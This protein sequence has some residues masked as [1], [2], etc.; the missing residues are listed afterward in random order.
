MGNTPEQAYE[1]FENQEIE[2]FWDAGQ[3]DCDYECTILDCLRGLDK[4]I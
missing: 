4:A 1:H 2:P 3:E